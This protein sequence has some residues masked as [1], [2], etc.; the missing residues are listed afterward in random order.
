MTRFILVGGYPRKAPDRGRA[1]SEELVSDFQEPVKLLLCYF[2]RPADSWEQNFD[3]D[4]DFFSKHLPG[5]DIEFKAASVEHFIGELAWANAL[6]IR[7]GEMAPLYER[8]A[9]SSGWETRLDGKTI[10]GSSA[11]AHALTKYNHKLDSDELDE[12]LGILPYKV[13][14]HYRSDYYAPN[15]DWNKA[16]ADLKNYKED[17]P[18]L[19]LREGEFQVF[20]Q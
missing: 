17:L 6:Y 7:G 19:T 11:G 12:G 1:F 3:E 10:A 13:L 18:L 2:A 8:L 16:E 9:Q 5:K 4:K 15:I 20:R 14:V